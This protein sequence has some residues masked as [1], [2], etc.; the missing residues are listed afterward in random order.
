MPSRER[1]A[2]LIAY[3]TQGKVIEAI[4]EF[5]AED[6]SMQENST[7][8]IVGAT[9]I[10]DHEQQFLS[11]VSEIHEFTAAAYAVEGDTSFINWVL[12]YTGTHGQRIRMEEVAHQ[13][14]KD[15]KIIAER[16]Y[17]D[18]APFRS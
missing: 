10:L 13:T 6:A 4:H 5:Y 9:A 17:Y 2:D 16:F 1:V 7:P 11:M 14:W 18:T 8:P 15:D 12:E 3:A